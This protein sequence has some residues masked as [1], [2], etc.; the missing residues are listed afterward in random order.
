MHGP[1][2]EYQSM[3]HHST[4]KRTNKH[5]KQTRHYLR[6][7]PEHIDYTQNMQ[8]ELEN[9]VTIINQK[10]YKIN[11]KQ[12]KMHTSK[13]A[14]QIL[15][16]PRRANEAQRTC[17]SKFLN[18]VHPNPLVTLCWADEIPGAII[19]NRHNYTQIIL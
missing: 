3:E 18:G 14:G 11:E 8:M 1:S 2:H 10:S 4:T 17:Y 12:N 9:A 19:R 5:L 7:S 15:K 16:S 6:P 13:I